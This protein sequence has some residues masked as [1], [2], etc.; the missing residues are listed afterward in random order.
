M[1]HKTPFPLFLFTF[2]RNI[3]HSISKQK[4]TKPHIVVLMSFPLRVET[5]RHNP[6]QTVNLKPV[7][8]CL[9]PILNSTFFFHDHSSVWKSD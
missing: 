2:H 8:V 4:L 1:R 6:F 5:D 9:H 3:I 7:I